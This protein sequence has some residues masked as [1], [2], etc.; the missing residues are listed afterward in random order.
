MSRDT[1]DPIR[2]FHLRAMMRSPLH[3]LHARTSEGD[4]PTRAMQ[5]GSGLHAILAGL[6]VVAY[7]EGKQRRGKEWEAFEAE[8]SG[9]LILTAGDYALAS[10]MAEALLSHPI[11]G[12]LLTAPS[13][14]HEATTVVDSTWGQ[15][16]STPDV[17]L[18][19]HAIEVKSTRNA[20]PDRF[21]WS[22]RRDYGYHTQAAWHQRVCAVPWVSILAVESAPP[23]AVVVYE[24]TE[25]ILQSALAEIEEALAAIALCRTRDEWPGYTADD[26]FEWDVDEIDVMASGSADAGETT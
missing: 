11:A 10:S 13:A 26:R 8:H 4:D 21:L 25:R 9:A 1:T 5:R 3:Y 22:G 2:H 18:L 14:R 23:H 24:L 12:P 6:P 16:R 20:D 7:H 17:L 15:L 19:G